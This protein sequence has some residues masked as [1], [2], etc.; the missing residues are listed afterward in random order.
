[1]RSGRATESLPDGRVAHLMEEDRADGRRCQYGAV[2]K[3][4]TGHDC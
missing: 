1:M 3:P 2:Q 4:E